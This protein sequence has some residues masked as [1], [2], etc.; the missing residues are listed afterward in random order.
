VERHW[1]SLS[2]FNDLKALQQMAGLEG[3]ARLNRM[4]D[5]IAISMDADSFFEIKGRLE[6]WIIRKG[7]NGSGLPVPGQ[8]QI[9]GEFPVALTERNTAFCI[10]REDILRNILIA[11]Q[12]GSGKTNLNFWMLKQLRGKVPFW[13]FDFSKREYRALARSADILVLRPEE[14]RFNLLRPPANVRPKE[15]LSTFCSLFSESFSLMTASEGFIFTEASKLYDIYGVWDGS[16]TCPTVRH[17]LAFLENN[18]YGYRTKEHGYWEV[19]V[20]RL[21]SITRALG[22]MVDCDKD[23]LPSLIGR[24]VVFELVGLPEEMKLFVANL[25]MLW[26]FTHR[27]SYADVADR[28]EMAIFI[29]EAS[30]LFDVK[31][32][33]RAEQSIPFIDMLTKQMRATGIGLIVSD[34]EPSRLAYSIKA[35]AGIRICFSLASGWD[36]NDMAASLDLS[37]KE[38]DVLKNLPVGMAVAKRSFGYTRPF[39]VRVPRVEVPRIATDRELDRIN[40]HALATLNSQATGPAD[41]LKDWKTK[42]S[43]TGDLGVKHKE[44][45]E[46]LADVPL[47]SASERRARLGWTNHMEN[48]VKSELAAWEYI[49]EVEINTGGRGGRLK[50]AELTP[51]GRAFAETIGKKV[52]RHGK[53]SLE[54]QFWQD[55]IRRM[56]EAR[57]WRASIEKRMGNA[58]LDV[59]AEIHGHGRLAVEVTL[60]TEEHQ[61]E[62]IRKDLESEIDWLIVASNSQEVLQ[63]LDYK[64]ANL[65]S[66]KDLDR[67][68]SCL[69]T[70]LEDLLDSNFWG[71]GR[72]GNQK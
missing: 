35:N 11:G 14:L 53:G 47:L 46:S 37:P 8:E 65:L 45:L 42:K 57:G 25:L 4:I 34:Q 40:S 7:R 12:A 71:K 36:V 22:P 18:N 66:K 21:R 15:W 60:T 31:K 39:I 10:D 13:A 38:K 48:K 43:A 61:F 63:S 1:D 5:G 30:R 49:Y 9:I 52:K 27:V 72:N 59:F 69:L 23:F 32:E 20:N 28:F 54:H 24:N 33:M 26:V 56:L 67:M 16:D 3:D 62:S 6:R 19:C 55:R 29:D 70:D 50:I 44:Y 41:K 58:Q 2:I 51:R 68:A 17:L 64:C